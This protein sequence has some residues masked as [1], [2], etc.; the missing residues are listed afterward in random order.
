MPKGWMDISMA[1][2]PVTLTYGI[3]TLTLLVVG[4]FL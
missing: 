1:N 4:Y 3:I 2:K